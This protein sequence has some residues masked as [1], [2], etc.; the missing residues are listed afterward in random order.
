VARGL[1]G[2]E[3]ASFLAEY[4]RVLRESGRME[5]DHQVP[6]SL[7]RYGAPGFDA[8][9]TRCAPA[10]SALSGVEL[11]PTYSF[12]RFYLRGQELVA[13]R[14]RPEC[15]HSATVHLAGAGDAEWP[16]WVRD[17]ASDPVSVVLRP[18]D[19]MLYRGDRVLHWRD[20]LEAEWYLQ[21]FLHY[22]DAAGPYAD[23][24]LDGRDH[25]ADPRGGQS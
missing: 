2:P 15:E 12:G 11:L 8:L 14:D 7:R 19:A 13:H 1:I 18:G 17:G 10:L 16:I 3:L 25:L 9:L 4:G 24:E 6:G 23:R 22:V 5:L 20:P 21:V